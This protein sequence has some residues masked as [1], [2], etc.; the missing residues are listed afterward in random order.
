MKNYKW[1]LAAL[2]S[3]QG[4]QCLAQENTSSTQIPTDGILILMGVT[5]LVLLI[6]I[7]ALLRLMRKSIVA[8]RPELSQLIKK[9]GA[10]IL[11]LLLTHVGLAQETA[12]ATEV[13]QSTGWFGL[14]TWIWIIYILTIIVELIAIGYLINIVSELNF[15]TTENAADA[16]A[17][18]SWFDRLKPNV[19]EEETAALDLNHDYD[20]I[21]ELD[22]RIPQWW[23]YTF[24]FTILFGV[25]YMYRMFGNHTIPSQ[26][27]Q[28]QQSI[29]EA[30]ILQRERDEAMGGAID[31]NTV[32]MVGESGIQNGQ[33]LFYANCRAC[34]GDEAQ[35]ASVGP[36]LTDAYW[37]HGG[38]LKDVFYS[39]KAGWPDKGMQSWSAILS[40][41]EMQDVASYIMSVQ[42]SSPPNAKSPQ[43]EL[44]TPK[45]ADAGTP[46]TDSTETTEEPAPD[47]TATVDAQEA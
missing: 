31:E 14:P 46:A 24:Y 22:N 2:L 47:S 7:L 28:L 9:G 4:V 26:Y 6:I 13:A 27:E 38:S 37:L 45:A 23:L 1:L 16:G 34:H 18:K 19:S 43:G 12:Q 20:G 17:K 44:Y 21:S 42:G 30:E 36:N 41:S 8:K 40:P 5:T 39:I 11:L 25:V 15:P 3:L 33:K 29:T 10:V 35:G 32:K